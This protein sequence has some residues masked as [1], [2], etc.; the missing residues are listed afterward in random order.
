MLKLHKTHGCAV[1]MLQRKQYMIHIRIQNCCVV[2]QG[3]FPS[4]QEINEETSFIPT[5][6]VHY[7]FTTI[8]ALLILEISPVM[9]DVCL[10]LLEFPCQTLKEP[11]PAYNH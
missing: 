4:K 6:T 3:F 10:G 5:S 9:H 8:I 1:D 7:G 11:S 2:L